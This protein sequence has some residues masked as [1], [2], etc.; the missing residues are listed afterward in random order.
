DP[1]EVEKFLRRAAAG[2]TT[3]LIQD[4]SAISARLP[5]DNTPF[6]YFLWSAASD[7][8]ELALELH[9]KHVAHVM[10]MT[11]SPIAWATS[12]AA[13]RN[14]SWR[15]GSE[16]AGSPMTSTVKGIQ[17]GLKAAF[18]RMWFCEPYLSFLKL[19]QEGDSCYFIELYEDPGAW[20][21]PASV[22]AS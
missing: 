22:K 19:K 1:A 5:L 18:W 9:Q 13:W 6:G 10:K 11:G 20:R 4:R 17:H 15:L 12:E 21:E 2:M 16:E 7:H 14:A 3:E 8:P